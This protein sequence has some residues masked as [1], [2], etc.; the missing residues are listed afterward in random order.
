M[1]SGIGFCGADPPHE[2]FTP[3]F[4]GVGIARCESHFWRPRRGC[5]AIGEAGA[6]P[7]LSGLSTKDMGKPVTAMC[8]AA[9]MRVA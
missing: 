6:L 9:A 5:V 8:V 2:V 1:A 4:E 7:V 3:L